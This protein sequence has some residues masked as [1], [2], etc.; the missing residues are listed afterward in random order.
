[1]HSYEACLGSWA[2]GCTLLLTLSLPPARCSSPSPSPPPPPPLAG[3]A[4]SIAISNVEATSVI[5]TV[6]PPAGGC[7]PVSF[8]IAHVRANTLEPP[9]LTT[10]PAGK[11]ITARLGNLQ[12][13]VAYTA[14]AV[15]VCADGTRTPPSAPVPF[16]PTAPPTRF[17][18]YI[19]NYGG[20]TVSICTDPELKKCTTASGGAGAPFSMPYDVLEV[21]ALTYVANYAL[22][23][24]SICTDVCTKA[25]G[26]DTFSRP[27]GL[28]HSG[29]KFYV[30]NFDSNLVSVCADALLTSCTDSDG[31]GT[32]NGPAHMLIVGG[33]TYVTNYNSNSVSGSPSEPGGRMMAGLSGPGVCQK[34]IS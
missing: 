16:T 26:G 15:G 4:A 29:S 31:T 28:A 6:T 12:T 19:A 33:T 21:G 11:S 14:T 2:G 27:N 10:V 9:S 24:V 22:N 5:V 8:V 1:M 7:T 3:Q 23:Y 20:T 25:T 30:A 17:L 32:F 18:A 34:V 13:G